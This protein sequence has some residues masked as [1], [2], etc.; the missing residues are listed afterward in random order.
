LCKITKIKNPVADAPV[1]SKNFLSF[2]STFCFRVKNI[3]TMPSKKKTKNG[4]KKR[5]GPL[6]NS[7]TAGIKNVATITR[8]T[9]ISKQNVNIK[10]FS[11]KNFGSLLLCSTIFLGVFQ[12]GFEKKVKWFLD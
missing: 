1:N 8:K 2:Y 11:I 4:N 3:N 5:R 7:W 12:L 6:S 10:D 9:A